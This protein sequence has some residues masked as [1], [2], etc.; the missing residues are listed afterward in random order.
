MD[1]DHRRAIGHPQF[2]PH[3][4]RSRQVFRARIQF[5]TLVA[6]FGDAHGGDRLQRAVGGVQICPL[7]SMDVDILNLA[8][9]A[10]FGIGR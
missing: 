7:G 4:V 9:L 1:A 10:A 8:A 6:Q 5:Q 2:L 3:G